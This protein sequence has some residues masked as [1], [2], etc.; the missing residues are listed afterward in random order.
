MIVRVIALAAILGAQQVQAPPKAPP[1][2]AGV[3]VW[4][5]GVPAGTPRAEDLDAV[6]AL[7]LT[8]VTWPVAHV[9]AL[10][11]VI[12]LAQQAGL[13]VIPRGDYAPL[14]AAGSGRDAHVDIAVSTMPGE[15]V[16][17]FA[18][19]ALA[20]GA[21]EIAFDSG[22][23]E[24]AGLTDRRGQIHPWALAA[25]GIARQLRINHAV[26]DQSRPGPPVVIDRPAPAAFDAVLLD[27]GRSWA[28]VATNLS[29]SRARATAHLPAG[30][31]YGL[32][33]D[34]L[35]GSTMAMLSE[36]SG[37][38][39]AVNLEG[40]GVRVYVIDKVLKSS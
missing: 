30:V 27:S 21:R 11:E 7:S 37:P 5:R 9:A 31:P 36:P 12:R 33:V 25:A 35:T 17:P 4:Y 24:G 23:P 8:R 26:I 28:L 38:K 29:P 1:E 13:T 3:S 15:E 40:W 18:W 10:P 39:W 16:T 6:A 2:A 34:L 19:R 22:L 20:H 14:G 32:W